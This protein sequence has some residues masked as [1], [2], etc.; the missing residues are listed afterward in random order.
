[1]RAR[2]LLL[3]VLLGLLNSGCFLIH[4]AT[5][6]LASRTFGS[7]EECAE[8]CRNHRWAEKA[9]K[10]FCQRA[11]K[12]SFSDDFARG[13]KE[14]FAEYLYEGGTGEPPPLPP[15]CYRK[16]CYQTPEGYQAIQDWFLGYRLGA[17]VACDGGYRRWVTGPSSLSAWDPPP[18]VPHTEQ[19]LPPLDAPPQRV[20]I[21]VVPSRREQELPPPRKTT[22]ERAPAPAAVP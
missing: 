8:R 6:V 16:L 13:F 14:G 20:P 3:I 1:M 12:A 15:R 21:R 2:F 9:W 5:S 18:E 22:S 7:L 4:E 19:E 17:V 10:D 11:G